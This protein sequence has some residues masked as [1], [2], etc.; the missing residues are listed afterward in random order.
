[1]LIKRKSV[2]SGKETEMDLPITQEQLIS[3]MQGQKLIQDV[4]PDLSADEREFL[5]TGI[6]PEEW[7]SLFGGQGNDD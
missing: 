4:M 6:T 2:L 1:M 7:E 5:M 3:W